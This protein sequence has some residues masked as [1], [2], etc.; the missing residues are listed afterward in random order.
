MREYHLEFAGI[1]DSLFTILTSPILLIYATP[2]P[3]GPK[4]FEQIMQIMSK[5]KDNGKASVELVPLDGTH[6]LHMLKP[7]EA[8][9]HLLKFLNEKVNITK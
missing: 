1:Y 9:P 7:A 5:I 4:L 6:H 2:P 8:A 3:Y